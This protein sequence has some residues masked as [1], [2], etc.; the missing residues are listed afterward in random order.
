MHPT[1]VRRRIYPW[2]TMI[3]AAA[4][5]TAALSPETTQGDD[6]FRVALA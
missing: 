4:F 5:H 3:T 6:G 2:P 1:A